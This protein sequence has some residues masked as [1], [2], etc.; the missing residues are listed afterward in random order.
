VKTR[1]LAETG[2]LAQAQGW[3]RGYY[4]IN[5]DGRV[6]PAVDRA[7]AMNGIYS[8]I[9]NNA[10]GSV[11]GALLNP[12]PGRIVRIDP[13]T[14][15]GE[16]YEPPF[17]NPQTSA[18]G[19]TPRGID[20]D[21]DGVIWTALA[22]SGHL[23]SFDRRKCRVLS[24][25]AAT[26]GQHCPEGWTL[27]RAPGPSFRN[28]PQE[29]ATDFQYYNFVDRFNTLGLGRN[30]PMANGTTSDSL[31]ALVNGEWVVLRVP[32]PMGFFTRGMDG[33]ID[34]PDAGWKGRGVYAN[35]GP[36]AAWHIEG[37]LGTKSKV[38]RFQLRPDPLAR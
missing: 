13:N 32:Y 30:V 23:A 4:D 10:D 37:G 20:I 35:Y 1:V 11:W 5:Q 25:E 24:G 26:S 3:C 19:Y 22:G 17:N 36:N 12:I 2:D 18:I 34:D 6:D 21:D 9:P 14:C 16:A 7:I 27:Y 8:V 38:V 33:R 28:A 31:L 29:I 15:L